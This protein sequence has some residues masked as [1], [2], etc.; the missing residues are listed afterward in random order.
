VFRSIPPL[1]TSTIQI[2][3]ILPA[4]PHISGQIETLAQFLFY[5]VYAEN[6]SGQEWERKVDIRVFSKILF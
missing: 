6:R 1:L 3:Q 2:I 4:L 5:A